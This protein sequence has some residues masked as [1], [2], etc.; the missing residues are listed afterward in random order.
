MGAVHISDWT[1]SG[2]VLYNDGFISNVFPAYYNSLLIIESF[3]L[4]T[5]GIFL[6][7]RQSKISFIKTIEN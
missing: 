7:N 1:I 3:G 2:H 5:S 4:A 6:I